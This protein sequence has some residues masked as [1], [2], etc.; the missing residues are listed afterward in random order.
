[1]SKISDGGSTSRAILGFAA[2]LVSCGGPSPR[3]EGGEE[4]R[5]AIAIRGGTIWTMA[6][7]PIEGGTVILRGGKIAEVGRDLAVPKDAEVIDASGKI[8][9]P[10]MIDAYTG[11]G[12]VEIGAVEATRDSDEAAGPIQPQLRVV[13]A[14]NPASEVIPVTRIHGITAVLSAPGEGNVFSGESAVMRLDGETVRAMTIL[15][16]AA[17][18]WNLGE[19]PKERYGEKNQAP[20]TRMGIAALARSQLQKAIDY[21]TKW[22]RYEEKLQKFE[23]G[24]P[25]P[26]E[27][28]EEAEESKK[29]H[30]PAPPDRDLSLEALGLALGGKVP[31]IARAQRVDDIVTAV[32]IAEE[33]GLRLI[34]AR[35]AEAYQ[36]AD[37]LAAKK[38]PVL[39]GPTTTQPGSIETLGAIYENAAKLHAAGVKIAIITADDHNVRTLPYQ[40][41]LAVAYGLPREAALRAVTVDAAEILGVGNRIGSIEPGKDA[42]IVVLDGDPFQPL[43]KVEHLFIGGRRILLESRQTKLAE[44]YR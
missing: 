34:L 40:A 12:L 19:P 6:G 24:V 29:P 5:K 37:L 30:R 15:A 2:L 7:D 36:V 3:A 39:V 41:G 25:E 35:A 23:A 4:G 16:P 8:V 42:D 21:R 11:L 1:M 28:G 22:E 17:I 20:A 26:R 33:F 18:H 32:R 13:D 38:I 10:G 43:T 27:E 44:K 9:M 31:V 14:F